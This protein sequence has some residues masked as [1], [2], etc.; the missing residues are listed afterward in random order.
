[1]DIVLFGIQGS[2]KGT[3]GKSVA[4]KYGF[5]V[6]ETGG[7]LRKLAQEDSALARKV[8]AIVESGQ[9]VPN[10]VVMDIIENFMEKLPAGKS[11]LFDGIPR[12]M[13]QA[14][15]FDALMKRN[16]REMLGILIDVPEEVVM[17]RL[18]SRR[19][20]ENCKTVYPA[21]YTKVTCEKC[22][23]KLIARTDDNPESIKNRIKAYYDETTPV[24][25]HYKN[26]NKLLT[27]NGNLNIE[28]ATKEI[29]KLLD[30]HLM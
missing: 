7:E 22:G 17:K 14:E 25:D 15:S 10:E 16:G 11:V 12:K 21:T 26:Q 8:K 24:I 2:G 27:M 20:C 30:R 18:T 13:A 23:G 19:L 28:D 5:V 1:M 3:L 9:L 4:E 6:F 29:F